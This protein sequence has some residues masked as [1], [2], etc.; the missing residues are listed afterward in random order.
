MRRPE[1][2]AYLFLRCNFAKACWDSIEAS[3][4]TTR[5]VTQIFKKVK[6]KL[7]V[8]FFMEIIILMAWSIWDTRNDW[9]FKAEFSLLLYRARA[10]L[11]PAMNT[12]LQT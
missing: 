2:T 1:T 5:T 11:L 7:A 3:V 4:I 12:W 8:P 10:T 9:I 6:E